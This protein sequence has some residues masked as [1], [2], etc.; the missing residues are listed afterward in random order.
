MDSTLEVESVYPNLKEVKMQSQTMKRFLLYYAILTSSRLCLAQIDTLAVMPFQVIGDVA[1]ADIYGYGLPDAIA[2]DLARIPGITVVE[3]IRLSSVLQE[4]ALSQAGIV[5]DKNAPQI[6]EM[7]G[8][9]V[10]VVGTVQKM[11][12]EVRVHARAMSA[13]SGE[14]MFSV[15]AE[16][17]IREFGDVFELED[18]L[19]QKIILQLGRKISQAKLDEIGREATLSED[20]FKQY[21]SSF[22]YFDRG[23]YEHGL[24]HLKR[25]AEL[26]KNFDW[27]DKVRIRA[28]Q[29][30]EELERKT[31]K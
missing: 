3:R 15:K 24:Q 10:I 23:E 8:A 17:K 25:A 29:A 27:A 4:M 11:G 9:N 18:F 26:D 30:F 16:K 2:N 13:V 6:G 7:L 1:N 5:T 20:A 14:V 22:R 31:N 12:D 19:A 21:S 28:Q